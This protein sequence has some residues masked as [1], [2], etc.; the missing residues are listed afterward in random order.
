MGPRRSGRQP[1]RRAA[2]PAGHPNLLIF[3]RNLVSLYAKQGKT[4][5]AVALLREVIAASRGTLPK[6]SPELAGQLSMLS[7]TL[8]ELKAW[9]EAEP[10]IRE[11]L[12]IYEKTQPDAWTTFN[13]KSMLGGVLLGQK[14]LPEAEPLL[15]EG[16]RRMKEPEANPPQGQ[17]RIPEALERLV[18]LYEAKGN[19]PEAAAWRSKLEAAQAA[20]AKSPMQRNRRIS[21]DEPASVIN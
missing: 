2:H 6:D 19:Q 9:D 3:K 1:E 17:S 4:D 10:L 12:T 14:K 5:N 13:T 15:L 8:L 11:A 16:Y 20:Q 18:R 7:Q 21:S